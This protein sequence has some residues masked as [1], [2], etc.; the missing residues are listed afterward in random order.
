MPGSILREIRAAVRETLPG[1]PEPWFPDLAELL[2]VNKW[3]ELACFGFDLANYGTHR[4]LEKDT[5]AACVNL[6]AF[7]L[8]GGLECR[9]EALPESTQA[10]YRKFGLNFPEIMRIDSFL[11]A[12]RSAL[13]LI[14]TV[15]TL[16][17]AVAVYLRALHLLEAPSGNIDVSHSDPRV[18]FSVFLSIPSGEREGRLRLAESIIHECMHLQLTMIDGLAP[19]V[20]NAEATGFSPWRQKLRPLTGILHGMYVFAVIEACF[21]AW[22]RGDSLAPDERAFVAGRR[23]EIK[24]ELTQVAYLANAKGLTDDGRALIRRLLQSPGN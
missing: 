20:C 23:D 1:Y 3:R 7:E 17:A 9:I 24:H 13:S 12:I 5:N 8:G 22:D 15:P 16:H 18:P 14:A 11:E 2:T 19:L 21:K 10:H 6:A 4:W